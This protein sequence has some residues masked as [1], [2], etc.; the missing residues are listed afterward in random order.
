LIDLQPSWREAAAEILAQSGFL[1]K[2]LDHYAY[3]EPECNIE[4]A[5]PDIVILGCATI[6]REEKQLM[7]DI[8]KY[9]RQLLV[10]C[11]ALPWADTRQVFLAGATD[12]TDKPYSSRNLL[13]I[14]SDVL[15]ARQ[16]A[17]SFRE[18]MLKK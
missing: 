3:S 8:L 16:P 18:R 11:A 1:V 14:V 5:P 13:E 4:G 7:H 15:S 12:V 6:K 2:T 9:E 10:L 17:D